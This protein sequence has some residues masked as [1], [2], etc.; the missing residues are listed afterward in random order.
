M[1]D[2][3]SFIDPI[4]QQSTTTASGNETLQWDN[5]PLECRPLT[6]GP[7]VR[8]FKVHGVY[9]SSKK[10][11]GGEII[12][13]FTGFDFS[14]KQMHIRFFYNNISLVDKVSSSVLSITA[15]DGT[16]H[17]FK[18]INPAAWVD[19]IDVMRVQI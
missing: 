14:S 8:Q 17:E 9:L 7:Y 4:Q 16:V 19:K 10:K 5:E 13:T 1:G 11:E 6:L 15:T 12:L 2:R 3:L 18:L